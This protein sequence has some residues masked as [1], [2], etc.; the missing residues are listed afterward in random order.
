MAALPCCTEGTWKRSA[1][2]RV[3]WPVYPRRVEHNTV[4]EGGDRRWAEI[5]RR[6][7]GLVELADDAKRRRSPCTTTPGALV[8]AAVSPSDTAPVLLGL[9]ALNRLGPFKIEEGRLVF[10]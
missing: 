2:Q 9:G 6:P 1:A 3:D 5:A 8:E 7:V 10:T 4:A